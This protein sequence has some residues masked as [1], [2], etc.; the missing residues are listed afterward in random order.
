MTS[1]YALD[2]IDLGPT[3]KHSGHEVYTHAVYK[4]DEGEALRVVYKKNKTSNLDLTRFEASFGELAR[5]FLPADL[6]PGQTLVKDQQG[7]L[8]GIASEHIGYVIAHR[9]GKHAVF[10]QLSYTNDECFFSSSTAN[11]ID[12]IPFYF[13]DGCKP[14]LFHALCLA[15]Q[16]KTIT[17]DLKSLANV[18]TTSYSLEEDDLHRGNFGFYVVEQEGKP[19]VVFF[20]IDHDLMLADSVM[21]HCHTRFLNWF[22]G[23]DAFQITARDL[24]NF[25][26][27]QDSQNYYWPTIKRLFAFNTRVAYSNDDD[28]SAFVD[29]AN[30]PEFCQHKWQSFYK[31]ILIPPQLI[32][33][34]LTK[35]LNQAAPDERAKN[36]LITQS[37]VA[38]QAKLRAVLFTIPTF[39]QLV[40]SMDETF[41][42]KLMQTI[43]RDQVQG[44]EQLAIDITTAMIF[45]ENVAESFTD[46]DTPLHAA[47]RLQDYR[48]HET[49]Q[50]FGHFANQKNEQG[51]TP[52]DVCVAMAKKMDNP[53]YMLG[54]MQHLLSAGANETASYQQFAA[55][56]DVR[57]FD[58]MAKTGYPQRMDLV[59]NSLQLKEVLRDLG[60]DYRYSLKIKKELALVCVRSFIKN[61][62]NNNELQ[63][64]LLDLKTYLN[65]S[66]TEPAAPELQFIRQLR[67]QLWIV[68]I[69]RGLF[70]G[71][72]TKVELN[73]IINDELSQIAAKAYSGWSFFCCTKP[74]LITTPTPTGDEEETPTG[75]P[76]TPVQP[77]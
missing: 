19:Q 39:R 40:T 62:K 63:S 10:N 38:R 71:T 20:K 64:I 37:V 41:R 52:L 33:Q 49:W 60:G 28:I 67:S 43:V 3:L 30:S 4:A 58:A 2:Q 27:L 16:N 1:F 56:C 66:N 47:I 36:A 54:V 21:S 25:P 65:G 76:P 69:V 31:H 18:L 68:R 7:E 24:E 9:E 50:D 11:T 59:K 6:T 8:T 44:K 42:H 61:Y 26:D 14:G 51:Q 46:G 72:A 74:P 22:H 15:A 53:D 57:S 35:H 45:Y 73:A 77:T 34:S 5:L 17:L 70:G 75:E 55:N 32:Q 12:D 48:Y 23:S 29:L 13:L